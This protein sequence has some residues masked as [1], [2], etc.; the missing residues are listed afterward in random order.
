VL[1]RTKL[2]IYSTYI[3]VCI[4]ICCVSHT[5]TASTFLLLNLMQVLD[6]QINLFLTFHT[7]FLLSWIIEHSSTVKDFCLDA[8]YIRHSLLLHIRE[9][10]APENKQ[11][12]GSLSPWQ[13]CIKI[14]VSVNLGNPLAIASPPPWFCCYFKGRTGT[15]KRQSNTRHQSCHWCLQNAECYQIYSWTWSSGSPSF[16]QAKLPFKLP[17]LLHKTQTNNRK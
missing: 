10:Q 6:L 12:A 11:L 9:P 3:Y 8:N 7:T 4:H 5:L 17:V 1:K 13:R 14:S 2:S 15:W 16:P